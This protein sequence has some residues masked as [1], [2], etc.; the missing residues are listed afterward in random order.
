MSNWGPEKSP[1]NREVFSYIQKAQN[2]LINFW[3]FKRIQQLAENALELDCWFYEAKI[4]QRK[5]IINCLK[6]FNISIKKKSHTGKR[7][8]IQFNFHF[9]AFLCVVVVLYVCTSRMFFYHLFSTLMTMNMM[10]L[11]WEWIHICVYSNIPVCSWFLSFHLAIT[12]VLIV[13]QHRHILCAVCTEKNVYYNIHISRMDGI[14]YF[15]VVDM[16]ILMLFPALI[17]IWHFTYD[18]VVV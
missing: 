7:K 4:S 13:P 11:M 8:T 6:K 9:H 14:I 5:K 18:I 3:N 16:T 1:T 12:F 15:Y 10:L 17:V 2:N